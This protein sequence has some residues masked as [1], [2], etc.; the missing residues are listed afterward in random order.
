[1]K[2]SEIFEGE[3]SGLR[4]AFDEAVARGETY[5]ENRLEDV[6]KIAVNRFLGWKLPADFNPDG[7]ISFKSGVCET[8]GTH[9]FT[10]QQANE[11]LKYALEEALT[12][13]IA[14]AIAEDR[15]LIK[16]EVFDIIDSNENKEM[17]NLRIKKIFIR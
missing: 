9:L 11:M 8:I 6:L 7:G 15:D 13:S 3:N 14:Q 4:I 2:P 10:A 5:T 16:R 17:Q 1:M 12:T